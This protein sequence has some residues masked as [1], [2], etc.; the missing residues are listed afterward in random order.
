MRPEHP[1]A[2]DN[3]APPC[4]KKNGYIYRYADYPALPRGLSAHRHTEILLEATF[5]LASG[6]VMVLGAVLGNVVGPHQ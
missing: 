4:L 1:A 5:E 6:E 3:K 2:H